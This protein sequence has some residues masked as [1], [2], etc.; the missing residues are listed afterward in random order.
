MK[1]QEID[2][3]QELRLWVSENMPGAT[4]VEGES[5]VVILTNLESSMGGYLHEREGK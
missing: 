2:T 1:L 4:V 3:I 5:G